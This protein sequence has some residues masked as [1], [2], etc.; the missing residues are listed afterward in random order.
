MLKEERQQRILEMLHQDGSVLAS[1]LSDVLSV[2]E[3]TIRRDLRDLFEAGLIQRVHG[4]AVLRAPRLRYSERVQQTIQG[5]TAIARAAIQLLR[6]GQ[7][8]LMDGGTTT[9][10]VARSIPYTLHATV[11]TNSPA[12]AMELAEHPNVDMI[13][14]GGP[15]LK[16]T[17][18]T[19]GIETVEA[20]RSY[21]ADICLLGI[22]GLHVEAGISTTE[23]EELYIKKVMIERS[24]EVVALASAE[25]LNSSTPY[26][27]GPLKLL[28]HLVTEAS[29]PEEVLM[30]FRYLGIT[31][32]KAEPTET[33][34]EKIRA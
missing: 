3:D 9:L 1:E 24:A 29:V 28:T 8:I 25:K 11:I 5:K 22:C 18:T 15:L 12:I 34:N 27:V 7:V 17:Q 30:P 21:Q 14:L 33:A 23:R 32:I 26:I 10:Q 20:L 2:S 19:A 13:L 31:T 4:G 16:S 6:D